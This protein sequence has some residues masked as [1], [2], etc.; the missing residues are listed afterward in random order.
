[1]NNFQ[2]VR[3]WA[4]ARNLIKGATPISQF[5]KLI[6][7]HGELAGHVQE[8]ADLPKALKDV[9]TEDFNEAIQ[10]LV[11]SMI[12]DV[13]DSLV[14]LT[15][16]G[17]Q[18]GIDIETILPDS[19]VKGTEMLQLSQAHGL[20]ADAILKNDMEAFNG[21]VS[22][23]FALYG[24]VSVDLGVTL[25]DALATAYEDIKDRKGVMYNGTFVKDS[26]ARYA[27]ILEELGLSE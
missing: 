4:E 1:M 25:D 12:D 9:S 8:M 2:K 6:S 26:D 23:L 10:K 3:A 22:T 24:V 18:L 7:E 19:V 20:L 14:V 5:A 13:G 21:I 17:A 27:S 15:I 11:D 16:I